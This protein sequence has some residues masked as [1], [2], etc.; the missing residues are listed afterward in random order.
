MERIDLVELAKAHGQSN[1]RFFVPLQP[2][3]GLVIPG[4][5]F[6]V[7]FTSSTDEH[8]L[9]ECVVDDEGR[10][11]RIVGDSGYGYKVSLKPLDERF[12]RRDYYVCDLE[13]ILSEGRDGARVRVLN[14]DIH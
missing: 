14:T 3:R 10:Y 1:L 13:S 7:A 9:V 4:M 5:G 11:P 8:E 6:A 2:L 12:E